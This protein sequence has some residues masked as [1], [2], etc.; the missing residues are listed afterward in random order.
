M[1]TE[2]FAIEVANAF[3]ELGYDVKSNLDIETLVHNIAITIS[4]AETLDDAYNA[5]KLGNF[6]LKNLDKI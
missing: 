6:C 2:K 3:Y 5:I 1:I 4:R